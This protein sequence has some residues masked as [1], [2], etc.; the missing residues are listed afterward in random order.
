[1]NQYFSYRTG[2]SAVVNILA[3]ALYQVFSTCKVNY[4]L[5]NIVF[6]FFQVTYDFWVEQS[7]DPVGKSLR[8][9]C[10]DYLGKGGP[11]SAGPMGL[12]SGF[13]YTKILRE[14]MVNWE[15][16]VNSISLLN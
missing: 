13:V 3:S 10:Y 8:L 6:F 4:L 16:T 7:E 1:M 9:A 12:L 2:H 11:F 5:T 14:K 15:I